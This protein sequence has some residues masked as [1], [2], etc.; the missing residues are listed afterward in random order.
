MKLE[1]SPA[2]EADLERIFLFNIQRTLAWAEK[3]ERHLKERA[4]TLLVTP[5][6]GRATREPGV[7]RLSAP[8]IQYVLDYRCTKD[9]IRVLRIYSTREIR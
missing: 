3:V 9:R 8:D 4:K 6:I 5:H 1:L 2:A 7:R